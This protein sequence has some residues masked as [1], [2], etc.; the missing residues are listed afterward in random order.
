[1]TVNAYRGS[2]VVAIA[3]SIGLLGSC[4]AP[5]PEPL[6]T[7]TVQPRAAAPTDTGSDL[8]GTWTISDPTAGTS[9]TLTLQEGGMWEAQHECGPITGSWASLGDYF[10][11]T[12]WGGTTACI[13]GGDPRPTLPWVEKTHRIA[14]SE[15]GWTLT[16][17]AGAV[18]GTLTDGRW[19]GPA[20][21]STSVRPLPQGFTVGEI[22]GRWVPMVTTPGESFVEFSGE[23]WESSDGCNGNSGKWADLGDGYFLSTPPGPQTAIGCEN[24]PVADW[25]SATRTAGFEGDILV[26]FDAAGTELGRLS[27]G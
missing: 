3:L 23:R 17:D 24:V 20:P 8:V 16:D 12:A 25:V 27:P 19:D 18:T 26:L 7:P 11:A 22:T 15:S 9:S 14:S 10:V 13:T 1:M 21:R 6:P 2:A 5:Q 4:T